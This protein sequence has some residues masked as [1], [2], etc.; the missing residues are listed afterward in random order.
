M[1][2]YAGYLAYLPDDSLSVVVLLNAE[3]PVRPVA[4]VERLV[5]AALGA[6]APAPAV[7]PGPPRATLAALAALAGAYGDGPAAFALAGD[8]LAFVWGGGPPEPLRWLGAHAFTNG[9]SRFTFVVRPGA[10][11]AVWADLTYV[12]ARWARTAPAR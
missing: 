12:V 9:A 7:G 6:A 1:G 10:P 8:G 2:G 3:G 4:I 11:P 5:E